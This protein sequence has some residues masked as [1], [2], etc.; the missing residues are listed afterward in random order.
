MLLLRKMPET[1]RGTDT[2]SF[3]AL[4][5]AFQGPPNPPAPALHRYKKP[6][7]MK[8][9]AGFVGGTEGFMVPAALPGAPWPPP[10][11]EGAPGSSGAGG[12]GAG[13]VLAGPPP[14]MPP[15]DGAGAVKM[16]DL[17]P[18]PGETGGSDE[19][20]KAFTL[21]GSQMPGPQGLRP[22]GGVPVDGKP[23]LW[24]QVAAPAIVPFQRGPG[25]S[26]WS[27]PPEPLQ[28][29]ATSSLAPVPTE[30]SQRLDVLTRQLESLTAPTHLQGTAE[31]FLFVAIGLLLL[32]AID[33]LLRFAVAAGSSV[34]RGGG[35]RFRYGGVRKRWL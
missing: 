25:G 17:F 9:K 16:D 28:A 33:T 35:R 10:T 3:C 20:Q 2:M 8:E 18:L 22:D 11:R 15:D 1:D 23:T 32:L 34:M 14:A 7:R 30:L 27:A 21:E 13:E 29:A 4:E 24:R 5:E 12:D 19:W 26:G 31:L 6:K